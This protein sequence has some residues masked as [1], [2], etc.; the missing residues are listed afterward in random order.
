M[1]QK[2]M[3]PAKSILLLNIASVPVKQKA[4]TSHYWM[5]QFKIGFYQPNNRQLSQIP[6]DNF[7]E[8]LRPINAG[9]PYL[10]G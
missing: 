6:P 3:K 8:A 10:P 2:A 4:V 1:C 9:I 5:E 7:P